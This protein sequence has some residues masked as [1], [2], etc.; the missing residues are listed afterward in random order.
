MV[1]VYTA[2]IGIGLITPLKYYARYLKHIIQSNLRTVHRR[3]H[4]LQ[5]E[6]LN[7]PQI[8][9]LPSMITTPF[10]IAY[11]FRRPT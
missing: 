11:P 1:N 9:A 3:P 10:N 6:A 8:C 5:K 4:W 7:S 2:G